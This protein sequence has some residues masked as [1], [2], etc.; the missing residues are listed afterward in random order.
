MSGYGLST[1]AGLSRHDS[2]E[3]IANYFAR[4]SGVAEYLERVKR[5]ASVNGYVTTVLGRRRY[6]P[7]INIAHR[8]AR[9]AAERMATNMP[10][11]GTAADIIKIAMIRLDKAMHEQ[12][13]RSRMILQ[14]HDELV[15]EVPQ[16]ELEHMQTLV[17][18]TME[19]AMSLS[20]RLKVDLKTGD[21]W[22]DTQHV[23]ET[24]LETTESLSEE[25]GDLNA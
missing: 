10:I 17:R 25:L 21:N 13:L 15:F 1:R 11:Q 22:R 18:D 2:D 14:V 5:D 19:H 20:V 6:L 12:K 23:P 7:E 3:F 16:D 24:G 4:Y 9:M 8:V